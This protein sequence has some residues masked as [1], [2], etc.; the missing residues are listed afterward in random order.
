MRIILINPPISLD[1]VYGRFKKL[2]SFQP[3]V[4]L[5]S[6]AGYLLKYKHDVSIVDCNAIGFSVSDTVKYVQS[7]S[8]DMVVLYTLSYNYP[9][10]EILTRAI[11]QSSPKIKIVAGGPHATFLPHQTLQETPIDFC[12][13][14]EGEETLLLLIQ[15]LED[16]AKEFSEIEGLAYKSLDGEIIINSERVR[17]KDLDEMPFPAI[18]LLPPLETYKLYLLH[19][20][21]SPYMTV[22]SSRGCPYKC[23]FCETPSGKIVR[24]HSPEY[25]VDYQ[26]FLSKKFGVKEVM[27][28]DDTFT[29]N[30]KRVFK[31]C[32]LMIKNN[33]DMTWYSNAHANVRDLDLFKSMKAAGCWIVAVG[34]ESGNQEV[35]DLLDKGTTKEQ[36]RLTC[37]GVRDA[38]IKLKTFFVLGNPGD[39][40]SRIDET[41][42][43]AKDLKPHFPVFSLMT[44]YPGAP[45]FETAE[46]YGTFDRAAGFH[47]QILA[48]NDPVFVP[49]GVTKKILLQKQK[50]AFRKSYFSLG[51]II[52]HLS[53]IESFKDI[54]VLIKAFFAFFEVQFTHIN[55]QESL[56]DE[57]ELNVCSKGESSEISV[58]NNLKKS[59]KN[60]LNKEK[61]VEICFTLNQRPNE[62]EERRI[63]AKE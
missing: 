45:L 52:R 19:H 23:V 4:G 28:L 54:K 42:Q 60:K 62:H 35:I 53:G 51:M 44:P 40:P 46:K 8:P 17:V 11:R 55:V 36:M 63:M 14:G 59:K 6:L 22:A 15:H 34:I 7:E 38:G 12:V 25:M 24:A 20:K 10:I 32:D 33:I 27:F 26:M 50:E 1:D 13:M 3:P 43:F 18:H 21:R 5:A 29:I 61:N 56:T 49:F 30:E 58:D 37:K 9:V 39:T 41:I 16:G 2:A 31:F 47:K 48:T 57:K